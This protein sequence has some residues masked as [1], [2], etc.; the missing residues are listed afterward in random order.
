MRVAREGG[1][2]HIL[3]ASYSKAGD[4]FRIDYSLQQIRSGESIGSDYVTGKGEES[5]PAMIDELKRKVKVNLKLSEQEIASD[6]DAQ[7]GMISTSSPEAFSY[8]IEGRTYH[9]SGNFER[10]IELMKKA[11]EI[12]PGFAMA[13]RSLSVSYG[14]L[15]FDAEARQNLE[16][17][18]ELTGRLPERERYLIQGDFYSDS[19]KRFGK[20]I[21]A[22]D[23]LLALY[24]DDRTAL[25][26][27]AII[28]IESEEFDKAAE[29]YEKAIRTKDPAIQP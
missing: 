23:K 8:Y 25:N 15:G 12:D 13:Y 11:V 14:N 5:F 18:F 24:P 17:A 4:I 7:V 27:S 2:N 3:K 10:S 21:A 19:E 22:Y 1:V 29:R 20:A 28:F 26:N 16:K 6:I 9:S